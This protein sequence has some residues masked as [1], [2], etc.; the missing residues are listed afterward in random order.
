MTHLCFL[1]L[2]KVSIFLEDVDNITIDL[3]NLKDAVFNS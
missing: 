3:T 2:M 1:C